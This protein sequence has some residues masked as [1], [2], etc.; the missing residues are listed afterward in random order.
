SK[1]AKGLAGNQRLDEIENS[2][3]KLLASVLKV[4]EFPF[5]DE[6]DLFQMGLD[7]LMFVDLQHQIGRHFGVD[8]EYSLL[9]QLRNL[10]ELA[11][12]IARRM[13]SGHSRPT[14]K[15]QSAEPRSTYPL[16]YNQKALWFL[17][18]IAPEDPA[19]NIVA[20]AWL[21]GDFDQEA[22]FDAFRTL[23]Q[24]HESLRVR[25]RDE[26]GET[27]QTL[28]VESEPAIIFKDASDWSC[29][30]LDREI[31]AAAGIPFDLRNES[32]L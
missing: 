25:F 2:L 14:G 8:L 27:V 29:D 32:P 12:E 30:A 16:S 23:V 31:S 10:T 4:E 20:A 13:E 22:L 26:C 28:Q 24:R 15:K 11:L 3:G 1:T 9:F 7:S 19:Y 5:S 21:R 6:F 18:Q 17:Y